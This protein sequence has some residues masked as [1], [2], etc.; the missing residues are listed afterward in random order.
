VAPYRS[1]TGANADLWLPCKPDSEWAVALGLLREVVAWPGA[2]NLPESIRAV[3]SRNAAA[4]TAEKVSEISGV[5]S[6][7]FGKVVSALG[8]ARKPLVLGTG[9]GASGPHALQVNVA[10]NLLNLCLD[11]DLGLFDFASRHRIGAAARRSDLK[12]LVDELDRGSVDLVLLNNVNPV[13]SLPPSSG[14]GEVLRRDSFFVVSFSNFMDETTEL[15]DLVLPVRLPLESW[16]EYG[17]K[18]GLVSTLQPA[19]TGLTGAPYLG[20]LLLRLAFGAQPLPADYR[21]YLFANLRA[22]GKVKDERHWLETLEHGGIFPAP[23]AAAQRF[24]PRPSSDLREV[25]ASTRTTESRAE[26]VL[27]AAPSIR[28]FDGRGANRP[29]LSE[30][31]DT[32]TQVAWQTPV[33]A[34]PET[35]RRRGLAQGDLVRLQAEAGLLEAP[36]YETEGVRRGVLVMT[37]GQGHTVYGRYAQGM[38]LSPLLLLPAGLEPGSGAP[39][40][41]VSLKGLGKTGRTLKFART[42][43]SRGQHGRKILVTTTREALTRGEVEKEHGLGIWEYPLVLPLPEHYDPKERDFYPPHEHVDYRWA[44]VVDL[45]RCIGC[46]ACAVACYAEN[47][48]GV[49][50]ER[51]ITLG[52]EMA[53]LQ[54][55]RYE[56]ESRPDRLA[57]LPMLCQQCDNAPCES[58]CPVFAS[59][60]DKEGL[61]NQI[62]NRCI[63]T[64]FC[65]QNCPYKVRR[66][67]W[68]TWQWPEP[69]NLQLNPDV[70]VRSKGV[71]EKCSFCVQRIKSARD[72]AKNEGR[73]IRDGEVVPACVQTCPAGVF[74]FGNLMDKESRVR[75]LVD[76]KRAYQVMGYLNTKPAVIY[77]KKV[78]Q[79]V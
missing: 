23:G 19:M 36:L 58:V 65:V 13:Y 54:I 71:M 22:E 31:P 12:T 45:D 69:L 53:W 6:E 5:P 16:D 24:A 11:P 8:R 41:A 76:D 57:F 77:L 18:T 56:N 78:V 72:V 15:A 44:M 70:T 21:A 79:E 2:R 47:N 9:T 25:F 39:F 4:F 33:L 46:A 17:G 55:Q 63:G 38:G 29:W 68:F 3:A 10:V 52:R 61:N 59:H 43:G 73:K 7:L 49:V 20:D 60:H 28:F 26:L 35:A 27:I 14:L 40:F 48:L 42:D 30:V 66:F 1:L 64:R 37:I 67:N 32:M 34:H 50:G 62:Y 74:S 51:W 75:K